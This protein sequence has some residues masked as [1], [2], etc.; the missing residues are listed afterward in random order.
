ME[1][2]VESVGGAQSPIC[3]P[4]SLHLSELSNIA[5]R[6]WSFP[7]S[8][9]QNPTRGLPSQKC[10]CP[11]L[12]PSWR[13]W[14]LHPCCK[15]Q[16]VLVDK[17]LHHLVSKNKRRV[18]LD[19]I[20]T[21]WTFSPLQANSKKRNDSKK[22]SPKEIVMPVLDRKFEWQFLD[23]CVPSFGL[24]LG[25]TEPTLRTCLSKEREARWIFQRREKCWVRFLQN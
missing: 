21:R 18:H 4:L 19:T 6:F 11:W 10:P 23:I 8:Q 9:R 14:L 3:V 5:F 2:W 24:T 12:N 1:N 7:A 13:G 15:R 20:T 25:F 17:A 16:D 22:H